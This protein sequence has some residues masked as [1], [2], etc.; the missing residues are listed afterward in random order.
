MRAATRRQALTT[1]AAVA[2]AAALPRS[3]GAATPPDIDAVAQRALAAF[4]VPGMAIVIV[5]DGRIV[6]AKGYG[7]RKL[8]SPERAD[9]ATA[10]AIGSNSKAFTTAALAVLVDEG[11]LRWEDRVGDVLPEFRMYDA[12]VSQQFTIIDLL[13]HRSGLGLGAGD[14]LFWPD[15]DVTRDEI[16]RRLRFLKPVTSFRSSFAYDNLLYVVAGEVVAKVSGRSW[17]DFVQD[18]LLT[19]LGM[20]D[21]APT[22]DR[23]RT[24]NRAY[25]HGRIGGPVRGTGPMTAIGRP[26]VTPAVGPA[27]SICASAR[28]MGRW[29]A[30][31]LGQGRTPEGRPIWS[32][33]QARMMWKPQTIIDV[34]ILPEMRA[35]ETHFNLYALGWF[36]SDFDGARLVWHL[37]GLNGAY[38]RVGMIPARKVGFAVLTN[39]EEGALHW[40]VGRTIIDHYLGRPASDLVARA[41]ASDDKYKAQGVAAALAARAAR[42]AGAKAPSLPLEAYAGLYRDPWYGDIRIARTPSGLTIDFSRTPMLRGG[43]EFWA[44]ET[45]VTRFPDPV[46]EDAYVTFS[47]DPDGSVKGAKMRAVSPL[48]DFSYDYQDLDLRKVASGAAAG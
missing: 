29:I 37:G 25:G 45:F 17:E 44:N 27:G 16:V 34:P 18:R 15:T 35:P 14:L 7:L 32:E 1:V 8:G 31:Q 38:S 28:D 30:T 6:H 11:K 46:A 42:P 20:A 21:S 24:A 19:P 4:D 2:G 10:F 41:K 33:A 39:A 22:Y 12:Y 9:E 13:T 40:A 23:L 3:S 43:L 5:E 26:R 47:V 48:A 36:V